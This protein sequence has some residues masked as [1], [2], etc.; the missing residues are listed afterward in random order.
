[1]NKEE[2]LTDF[3]Q[4]LRVAISNSLA[5]SPQHPYFLKNAQEF[6]EKIEQTFAYLNPLRIEV[7]PEAL[8]LGGKD[9]N[10]LAFTVELAH[11]LHQRKIKGIEFMPGI[12]AEEAADFLALLALQPKEVIKKGGLANLLSRAQSRHIKVIDLDYSALLAPGAT[13]R[14]NNANIEKLKEAFKEFNSDDFVD[15]LFSQLTGEQRAGSLNLGLFSHLAGEENAPK[16]A[17]GLLNKIES[18]ADLKKDQAFLKRIKDLL[19]SPD[20]NA[21]PVYRSALNSLTGG[22]AAA[23]PAALSFDRAGLRSNY[24][25]IILDLFVQEKSPG[26]LALI[27]K[28][29][30]KE[31]EAV[32]QDRDYLF[33]RHLW[34]TLQEKKGKMPLELAEGIER[35]IALIIENA[36]WDENASGDLAGMAASLEKSYSTADLYL[37]KIFQERRITPCGLTLF[38]KFFP[39]Q[40]NA[41]YD[42]LKQSY[43]DLE[44]LHQIIH[45]LAQAELPLS[46]AVLKEIFYF[47]NDLIKAEVLKS[48]REKGKLDP[49]FIFPLL[50]E[51]SAILKKGALAALKGTSDRQKA[52]DILLGIPSPWGRENQE[53]IENIRI[54]EELDVREAGDRLLSLSARRFFWNSRLRKAA[55]EVLERWR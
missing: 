24:R 25:L 41:F 29:L 23:A 36:I 32:E 27:A 15:L 21:S 13:F 53:I 16:I 3:L 34:D 38:L 22:L 14:I 50:K 39:A 17:S 48:A 7:E 37:N 35:H 1:M 43:S 4:G 26:E 49:E 28:R 46:S 54:I 52:A 30:E 10:K 31:W 51:K 47:G 45:I 40:L 44:L 11:L 6:K 9:W 2:A 5:Y 8:F 19:A 55:N 12:S 33:L 18:R 20:T 42:L